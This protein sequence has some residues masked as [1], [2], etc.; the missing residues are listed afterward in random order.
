MPNSDAKP[1]E[2]KSPEAVEVQFHSFLFSTPDTRLVSLKL[3]RFHPW[4]KS[5]G[6]R[7]G[8]GWAVGQRVWIGWKS[9]HGCQVVQP[10]AWLL[11]TLSRLLLAFPELHR[12]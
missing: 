5:A 4:A 3:W 1:N 10:V 2:I 6:T 9:S 8:A 12:R 11:Y 7:Q